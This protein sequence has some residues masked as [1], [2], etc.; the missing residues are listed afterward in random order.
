MRDRLLL[1]ALFAAMALFGAGCE[2]P[3]LDHVV[4]K[5]AQED[6]EAYKNAFRAYFVS[7]D[8]RAQPW[9]NEFLLRPSRTLG[10]EK[11]PLAGLAVRIDGVESRTDRQGFLALERLRPGHHSLELETKTAAGARTVRRLAIPI[12][13]GRMTLGIFQLTSRG[14]LA[15][16][17]AVHPHGFL[18]TTPFREL[19][20]RHRGLLTLL[21]TLEERPAAPGLETA[22][23]PDYSDEHGGRADLLKA[24]R[25]ARAARLLPALDIAAATALVTPGQADLVLHGRLD[26]RPIVSRLTLASAP[27]PGSPWRILQVAGLNPLIAASGP[28]TVE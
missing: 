15:A 12:E 14:R 20:E 27:P 28:A 26:G 18:L 3:N 24:R 8:Q 6:P 1:A 13:K 7:D 5:P 25:F 22:L 10:S 11:A 4:F 16:S 19:A 17:L 2:N 23:D 9:G 21:D